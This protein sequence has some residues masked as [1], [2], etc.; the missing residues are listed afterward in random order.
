MYANTRTVVVTVLESRETESAAGQ[1]PYISMGPEEHE[2]SKSEE[3]HDN[4]TWMKRWRIA[5]TKSGK[6]SHSA[7]VLDLLLY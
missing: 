1:Q 4:S 5:I 6:R 2:Q 3:E 7:L